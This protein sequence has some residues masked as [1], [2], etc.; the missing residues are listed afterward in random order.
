[1][2]HRC[3]RTVEPPVK[4]ERLGVTKEMEPGLPPLVTDQDRLKQILATPQQRGEIHAGGEH[5]RN[6][7]G[8]R[9]ASR[10]RRRYR[11]RLP[12]DKLELI[13][14]EFRQHVMLE[15]SVRTVIQKRGLDCDT[16]IQELRGLLQSYRRP[17]AKG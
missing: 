5:Y 4:S 15:Q 9:R 6:R 13:F 14:E 7:Q 12:D 8:P 1:M 16:L 11:H 3:L 2:P 17:T 10:R